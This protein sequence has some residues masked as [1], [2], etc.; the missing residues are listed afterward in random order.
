M[1]IAF[2]SDCYLDLTG[3]IVSSI[4]AQKVALEKNG[5]TVYIFSSGYP[6][7]REK[8]KELAKNHIY[9]VPSCKYFFKPLTPVS[10]RPKI[11]ENWLLKTHP[12]LKD[13]NIFYTLC[14]TSFNVFLW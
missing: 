13:F 3:G 10:R 11:I 5:H 4:N 12:E 6:R 2:F 1:K 7:S 14:F 9:Q 8:L